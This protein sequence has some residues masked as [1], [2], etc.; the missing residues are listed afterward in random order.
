MFNFRKWVYSLT[1]LLT[2]S[3]QTKPS[4]FRCSGFMLQNSLNVIAHQVQDQRKQHIP[5]FLLVGPA[6]DKCMVSNFALE[7][8]SAPLVYRKGPTSNEFGADGS[9]DKN[10][11]SSKT[12]CY[13]CEHP[14]YFRSVSNTSTLHHSFYGFTE[15]VQNI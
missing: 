9:V 6:L 10:M 3:G 4:F 5:W 8:S 12:K 15:C 2:N 1:D 13:T 11:L 7:I 14:W